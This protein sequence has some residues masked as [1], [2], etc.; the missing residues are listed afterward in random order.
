MVRQI[1][2]GQSE[3]TRRGSGTGGSEC[4]TSVPAYTK[5]TQ[6]VYKENQ[7]GREC[8]DPTPK[9]E[10]EALNKAIAAFNA[11]AAAYCAEGNNRC[12]SREC[13]H[14]VTITSAENLGTVAIR[15]TETQVNCAIKFKVV[16]SIKCACKSQGS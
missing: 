12:T 10:G 11:A 5:T 14:S 4:N 9:E 1:T 13:L 15:V 8:T 7:P 6:I 2:K 3:T 16:G